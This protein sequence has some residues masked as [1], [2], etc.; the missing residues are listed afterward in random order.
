MTL[1]QHGRLDASVMNQKFS[2]ID[3]EPFTSMLVQFTQLGFI[4]IMDDQYGLTSKGFGA[5]K[6]LLNDSRH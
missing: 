4:D 1:G 6:N 5:Y 3:S 2:D